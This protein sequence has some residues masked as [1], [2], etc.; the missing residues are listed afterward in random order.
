MSPDSA[1]VC[2]SAIR[3]AISP[4]IPPISA[5]AWGCS[6]TSLARTWSLAFSR[7]A[8]KT[9]Q[10]MSWRRPALVASRSS[11]SERWTI[12]AKPASENR[13]RGFSTVLTTTPASPR[14]T[15]TSVIAVL[16]ALRREIA[17]RC[18]WLFS[19][20][21]STR[22][23]SSSRSD[24]AR[25][26]QATSTSSSNARVRTIFGGADRTGARRIASRARAE[27]S[28]SATRRMKT[29]RRA[30]CLHRNACSS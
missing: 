14:S 21:F 20:A 17:S 24:W 27:I 19:L 26:G 6:A 13:A 12:R 10:G 16:S 7:S 3:P 4:T 23:G 28:I 2:S 22:V 25:T 30:R 11:P 9:C 5:L 18:S 1:A 29:H 8:V 15:S